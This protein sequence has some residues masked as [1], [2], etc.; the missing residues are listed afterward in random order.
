MPVATFAANK[1]TDMRVRTFQLVILACSLSL[2]VFSCQDSG[3]TANEP[4]SSSENSAETSN[5]NTSNSG[6][7]IV[8]ID[9]DS[10]QRGYTALRNELQQL[11]ENYNAA[12]A[13][14]QSRVRSLQREVESLQNQVQRGELSQNRIAQEQERI[15]RREQ[16]ILQQQ[17]LSLNSIQQEQLQ[18]NAQFTA[19]IETILEELK[20]ANGYDFV[21]NIGGGTGLLLANDAYDITETVLEM[22]NNKEEGDGEEE[23]EE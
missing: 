20:E 23:G 19:E 7:H 4:S 1:E 3:S 17:Q 2:M 12:E 16:E 21:F 11:E 18:L 14:H 5:G 6:L 22:L 13:N 10:L 9:A 15:A 8:Y